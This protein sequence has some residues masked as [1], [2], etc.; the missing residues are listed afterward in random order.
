MN[1]LTVHTHECP[2]CEKVNNEAQKQTHDL[3]FQTVLLVSDWFAQSAI[4]AVASSRK[5][6]LK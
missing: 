4:F 2:C 1:T 6:R 3:R 5:A